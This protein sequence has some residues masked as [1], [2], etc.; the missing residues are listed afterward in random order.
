M[1]IRRL[2]EMM[3]ATL[4]EDKNQ[5]DAAEEQLKQVKHFGNTPCALENFLRFFFLLKKWT[6]ACISVAIQRFLCLK[7]IEMFRIIQST[8]RCFI[9]FHCLD[10][11]VVLTLV[12]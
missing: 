5:R 1:D 6:I 12:E 11:F 9:V 3:S 7:V 8:A 2:A 10:I 4:S